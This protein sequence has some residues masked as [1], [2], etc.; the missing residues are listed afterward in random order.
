MEIRQATGQSYKQILS[1]GVLALQALSPDAWAK[2]FTAANDKDIAPTPEDV[3]RLFVLLSDDEKP[4][5][6]EML[7]G[8]S[9]GDDAEKTEARQQRTRR[10]RQRAKGM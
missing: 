8:A 6:I 1:A 5:A 2:F 9:V 3:C 10:S 7:R 4:V